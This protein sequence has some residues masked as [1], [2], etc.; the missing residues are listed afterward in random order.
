MVQGYVLLWDSHEE[1]STALS[2]PLRLSH[3][4]QAYGHFLV[5]NDYVVP[6]QPHKQ[7]GGPRWRAFEGLAR[8]KMYSSSATTRP[9]LW[10]WR[11]CTSFSAMPNTAFMIAR[12]AFW[13]FV[14][15]K[16]NLFFIAA[17][18]T[19][20][21]GLLP[22]ALALA[23]SVSIKRTWREAG[24]SVSRNVDPRD[25]ENIKKA[26]QNGWVITFPQGTTK[27]YVPG[28]RGTAH[29]IKQLNPVVVPVVIDGYRRAFDKKGLRTKKRGS[30][31]RM[32]FK[33]PMTFSPDASP[34]E[35]LDEIMDAIEQSPMHQGI[36]TLEPTNRPANA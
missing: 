18:E 26:I 20:K 12:I 31:L 30:E 1:K 5:W 24:K 34:Q 3:L 8:P 21:S 23:G 16:I 19:M 25:L 27:P 22:R 15:P 13:P 10:M 17:K 29:I 6:L 35:V 2:R 28:R 11:V 14:N 7:V 4:G 33:E 36:R 32:R 9:I